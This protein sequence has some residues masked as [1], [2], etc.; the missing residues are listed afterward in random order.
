[1]NYYIA[2]EMN[3]I[4][5]KFEK[6]LKGLKKQNKKNIAKIIRDENND[7]YLKVSGKPLDN[8][9]YF[10]IE[11]FNTNPEGKLGELSNVFSINLTKEE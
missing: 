10:R 2:G 11:E 6:A 5:K 4:R 8:P 9:V 3:I 1:M 7:V